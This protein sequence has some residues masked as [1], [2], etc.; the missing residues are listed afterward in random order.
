MNRKRKAFLSDLGST[1]RKRRIAR[2][3]SQTR[4]ADSADITQKYLCEIE[5]GKRNPSIDCVRRICESLDVQIGQL[6][7]EV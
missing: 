3:W 1:I 2:D 7:R 6:F 4:L 5:C